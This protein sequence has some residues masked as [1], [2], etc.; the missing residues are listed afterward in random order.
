M[1]P[2]RIGPIIA[3]A[4]ALS[5]VAGCG[6]RPGFK[7]YA[8]EVF[9]AGTTTDTEPG[10]GGTSGGTGTGCNTDPLQLVIKGND[11][12]PGYEPADSV[13]QTVHNLITNSSL[14]E[15]VT[16]MQ[17]VDRTDDPDYEDIERSP[18]VENFAGEYVRGYRYRDA[19]KGVNLDAGQDNRPSDGNNFATTFPA[20][21]LRAASWDMDL[22]W[23]VGQAMGDEVATTRN[24]MLLAPCI[25]IVR[26]PYWGRTQETYGEDTYHIGRMASAFAAGLQQVVVGCA[27]HFAG[28]NVERNRAN[29]NAVMLPP[30]TDQTLREIYGRHFEMVIRDGGV[31][32]IMAAYNMVNG[33]KSTQNAHLLTDI[34]R[35]PYEDG[36]MGYRGLVISDWWAMP[37]G[38][39]VPSTEIALERAKEA[40]MAGLDIEVP[41]TLNYGSLEAAVAAGLDQSYIE[42]SARRILEQKLR[43]NT[44]FRD[45]PWGPGERTTRL[46]Q[47]SIAGNEPHLDLAEEAAIKSAVLLKNGTAEAPVLPL[48]DPPSVAVLG[49]ELEFALQIERPAPTSADGVLRLATQVSVGDRGSSRVNPDPAKSVGPFAG[50]QTVIAD[51]GGGTVTSGTTAAEAG[52]ADVVVVIVGLDPAD[53]GEEYAIPAQGDRATLDLST[54]QNEFV[55]QVLDLGKRTVI[56]IE[57]GYIVNVP[58][59][60]H[61]NQNQATVWLGYAGQ[62]GGPA[63]ARLLFGEANFSGK[64]PMA[65]PRQADL[66]EFETGALDDNETE[67]GYF[68]GYREYDRRVAAGTPVNLVFPFGWGLSY[69][70]FSYDNL[71]IP[72]AD[73]TAEG[74]VYVTVDITNDGP[75]DG[76][77][78]AMLFVAGPPKPEGIVGERNVKELKSFAKVAVATGQTV[79]ATLPLRVQDLRHWEGGANGEWVIDPGEYTILVGPNAGDAGNLNFPLQGTLT[80]TP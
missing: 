35:A 5:A 27:K 77:E 43:F 31:G 75:V 59:L 9:K 3:A 24:N 71:Q 7:E 67:M 46:E 41:W 18:D 23:R 79:T 6:H 49:L 40:A 11:M 78:I 25:N 52:D 54:G 44:A 2:H 50:I 13:L 80:I 30:D 68:F 36:G 4:A 53:E 32:C 65:W 1:H 8:E 72:C 29:Q 61:A 12:V 64:M 48:V 57:S 74:V 33:V 70:T 39:S 16:Q 62:R 37:G 69:T 38:E 63:L 17:G 15:W 10:A 28:N 51:H 22:E 42:K 21:S 55:N 73:T 20:P 34:L 76:E 14:R 45:D 26:H 56:V 19:G 47:S 58:W 66:P 60:D